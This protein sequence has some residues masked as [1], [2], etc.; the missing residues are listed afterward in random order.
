AF[1]HGRP[2]G[3]R[4][5]GLPT[6]GIYGIGM[7]RAIYKMGR[8]ARVATKSGNLKCEIPFTPEWMGSDEWK[9]PVNGTNERFPQDGTL[10]EITDIRNEVQQSFSTGLTEFEKRLRDLIGEHYAYLIDRGFSVSI[11][12]STVTGKPIDILFETGRKAAAIR[13]Y[14]WQIDRDGIHVF[15]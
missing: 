6:V 1:M 3:P 2:D 5:G 14:F 12:G 10:V 13:P 8:E 15:L 4:D 9:L 11:N 7:K